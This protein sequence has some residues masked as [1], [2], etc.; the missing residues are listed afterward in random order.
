MGKEKLELKSQGFLVVISGPSGAGKTSITN[1]IIGTDGRAVRS[2]SV[3]TRPPRP[4]EIDGKDYSFVSDE[5][6][7][8]MITAKELIEWAEVHGFLYGT[9]R[10]VVEDALEGGKVV[11]LDID[12]QG[13]IQIRRSFPDCVGIFVIPKSLSSLNKRLKARNT[14]S[15]ESLKVRLETVP[16]EINEI[17]SYEY[18]VVNDDLGKAVFQVRSII[19]AESRR[20]SRVWK[21]NFLEVWL[22]S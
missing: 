2:V 17:H 13:A 20:A 4:G 16:K 12:V 9:P 11:I 8:K 6:F 3:T 1:E 15:D 22:S 7:Q 14:E 18:L 10:S 21:S 19:E 5:E